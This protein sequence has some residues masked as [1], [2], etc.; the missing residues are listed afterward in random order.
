M[1]T[2]LDKKKGP[3][4]KGELAS[5]EMRLHEE[6]YGHGNAVENVLRFLD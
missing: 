6:K 2:E 5:N 3:K 4:K 1:K